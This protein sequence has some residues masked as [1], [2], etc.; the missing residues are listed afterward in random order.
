MTVSNGSNS[1]QGMSLEESQR[2][3]KGESNG[4]AELVC[5]ST[6]GVVCGDPRADAESLTTDEKTRQS[7]WSEAGHMSTVL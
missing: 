7:S 1:T 3:D 6:I 4:K 5:K 2:E